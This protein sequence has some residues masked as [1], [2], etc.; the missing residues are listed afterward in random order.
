[1]ERRAT[2]AETLMQ[3]FAWW[4]LVPADE[5]LVSVL[6]AGRGGPAVALAE[7]RPVRVPIGGRAVARVAVV[8]RLDLKELK[9]E[10]NEAP[11][12]I[13]LG[14]VARGNDGL[15]VEIRAERETEAPGYA[16]NLIVAVFREQTVGGKDGTKAEVR[17]SFAGVLPAIPIEL[18]RR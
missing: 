7:S 11:K 18:F 5:F 12:G 14:E 9:F 17:R 1:V 8:G 15:T 4:H 13:T 3:A 16:D 6:G 2:P 10:L